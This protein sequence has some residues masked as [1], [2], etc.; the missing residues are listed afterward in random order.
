MKSKTIS[1]S[2]YLAGFKVTSSDEG[3]LLCSDRCAVHLKISIDHFR[4]HHTSREAEQ[5]VYD[6][7]FPS[8]DPLVS[9][10]LMMPFRSLCTT[11][12]DCWP[13]PPSL[14]KQEGAFRLWLAH[15]ASAPSFLTS[16]LCFV[17]WVL[18]VPSAMTEKGAGDMSLIITGMLPCH[19]SFLHVAHLQDVA[20]SSVVESWSLIKKPRFVVEAA[21]RNACCV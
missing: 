1:N 21:A 6:C 9:S 11:N 8:L 5:V 17:F 4:V 14:K 12:G 16:F 3:Q 2:K 13:P 7:S 18:C 19:W 10:M 15:L 20:W